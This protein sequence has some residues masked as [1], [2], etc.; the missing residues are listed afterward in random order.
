MPLFTR[1]NASAWQGLFRELD[2]DRPSVGRTVKVVR[3][4]KNRGVVG[5]VVWHGRDQYYDDRYDS[6]AQRAFNEAQGKFGYRVRISPEN[7]PAF[8]VKAEYVD[9]VK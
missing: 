8:F 5:V 9:V 7:G 1:E 3:G 2:Q 4:R 6:S